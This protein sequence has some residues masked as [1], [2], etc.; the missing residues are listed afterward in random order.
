MLHG[1]TTC[2]LT[3]MALPLVELSLAPLGELSGQLACGTS[4]RPSVRP[5]PGPSV[6][7]PCVPGCTNKRSSSIDSNQVPSFSIALIQHFYMA[8]LFETRVF[9]INVLV[10][11]CKFH[12]KQDC[13]ATKQVTHFNLGSIACL[14]QAFLAC[15][16]ILGCQKHANFV[17][18][19][20]RPS[21][22]PGVPASVYVSYGAPLLALMW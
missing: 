15:P 12:T 17:R 6:S 13:K 10:Y 9:C 2:T 1:G 22:F 21:R 20:Q 5:C 7:G 8:K 18:N 19:P 4:V 3:P 11:K 14:S 16:I